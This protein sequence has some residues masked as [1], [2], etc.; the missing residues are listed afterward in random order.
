MMKRKQALKQIMWD[1]EIWWVS[2]LQ[3]FPTDAV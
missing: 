1:T 2:G 3:H